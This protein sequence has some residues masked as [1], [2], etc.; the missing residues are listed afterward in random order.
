LV[1]T[2]LIVFAVSPLCYY[3]TS[4]KTALKIFLPLLL[5]G[6]LAIGAVVFFH[7]VDV[8]VL[9]PQGEIADKQRTL[10][11]FA[12]ALS[13]IIVIPVYALLVFFAWRYRD[14][15]KKAAYRPNWASNKWLE[16]TWWGIPAIIVA[17]LAVV[18][19]RTSHELDQFRP[20][21][22]DKAQLKI[23]VVALQWKWLFIYPE[24]KIASVNLMQI[25]EQTP[26]S[27]SLTSDAPMNAFWVPS[28]GSQMYAMSGM[29]SQLHLLANHSGD[30]RGSSANISG[31]G[32]S[33]MN[34]TV[35]ASSQQE[36]DQ[37]TEDIRQSSPGLDSIT[38]GELAKPGATDQPTFYSL[39]DPDLYDK[40]IMKYMMPPSSQQDSGDGDGQSHDM[41]SH[42]HHEMEGM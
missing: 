4:M 16:I 32:F 13:L 27:L 3:K 17:M 29:S 40:I 39:A 10:L 25:P 20:I 15:N 5:V 36:F 14:S 1:E 19:F 23:Q 24:Q 34:F 9:N 38:Y 18:A 8:A 42:E 37:W 41:H 35:R 33:D 2:S 22:S 11:I 7:G 30:Y 12:S 31:E 6:I 26:V 21:E 28:L